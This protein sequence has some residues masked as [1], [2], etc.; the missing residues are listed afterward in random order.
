V[1]IKPEHGRKFS[2]TRRVRLG[3]VTPKGRMRLD[4]AAR[5]LQDIAAD[6]GHDAIGPAADPWVV[7]RTR[8]EVE[9]FP[10]L[11]EE[12]EVTTWASAAGGRWAERRTSIVGER[13]GRIEGAALW[14]YVDLD[15][16]RPKRLSDD[17]WQH[18][19]ESIGDETLSARLH[20]PN[21]PDGATVIAW[22]PRFADF[23]VLGH[24]NNAVYWAIVEEHVDVKAPVSLEVEFRGGLDRGQ[25]VEV[26]AEGDALWILGDGE[27]AASARVEQAAARP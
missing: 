26:V 14:V 10:V 5:Y 4:A 24:V 25:L 8:F 9:Q 12:V 23:D 16:G 13:G 7:R 22:T 6:D 18:Y 19:G 21:S 15:T 17:F 3:D 27:V 1:R 20:H 11:R 2:A